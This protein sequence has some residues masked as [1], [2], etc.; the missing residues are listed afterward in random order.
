MLLR[1]RLTSGFQSWLEEVADAMMLKS[2]D[3]RIQPYKAMLV[4]N[5]VRSAL[6]VW[7][8]RVK[9]KGGGPT[10]GKLFRQWRQHQARS[11]LLELDRRCWIRREQKRGRMRLPYGKLLAASLKTWRYGVPS[12]A[13]PCP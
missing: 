5:K 6:Q 12:F 11:A 1:G 7:K 3:D 4:L 2:L 10:L 8:G 9:R 13:F